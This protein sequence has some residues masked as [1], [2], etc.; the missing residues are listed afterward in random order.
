MLVDFRKHLNITTFTQEKELW[1]RL[2]DAGVY[3]V[4]CYLV[5][6]SSYLFDLTFV[7]SGDR[8]GLPLEISRILA[9]HFQCQSGLVEGWAFIYLLDERSLIC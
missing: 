6:S 5:I 8:R 2:L 1:Q 7:F 9:N 3:T 4:C